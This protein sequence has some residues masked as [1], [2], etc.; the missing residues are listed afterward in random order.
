MAQVQQ[1]VLIDDV[2]GGDAVETITFALDGVSYEIDLNEK[3]A[4]SMREALA[5][6]VGHARKTTGRSPAAGRGSRGRAR[7]GGA[8][9]GASDGGAGEDTAAV[10]VW[11]RE[12]GHQVNDRGRVSGTV[13]EAYRA[14]HA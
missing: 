12:N 3:N 2:E 1:T 9:G 10:R 8:S 11:A 7:S 14:A 6:W 4:Q 13:L 5:P